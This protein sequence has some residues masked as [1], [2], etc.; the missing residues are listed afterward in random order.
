MPVR[1]KISVMLIEDSTLDARVIEK[2]LTDAS[3]VIIELEHFNRLDNG[4]DRLSRNRV[5]VLLLDLNLPDSLGTQTVIRARSRFPK[6]PIV[7]LTGTDERGMGLE[8]I[9]VGAQD[10]LPKKRMDSELLTRSLLY[11][12]QRRQVE[13]TN[14][15]LTAARKIQDR[16]APSAPPSIVSFDIA[17]VCH[18]ASIAGGDYFDYIQLSDGTWGILIADVSGHG[19]GPAMLMGEV[20]AS[21]R[22]LASVNMNPSEIVIAVNSILCRDAPDDKFITLFF[23]QLDP[24][25]RTIS[26]IGAGHEAYLLRGGSELEVLESSTISLAMDEHMNCQPTEPITLSAGDIIVLLTDGITE[27]HNAERDPFGIERCLDVVRANASRPASEIASTVYEATLQFV[28]NNNHYE[29]DATVVIVKV[30]S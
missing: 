25:Q 16:L 11:A 8:A 27:A 3:D 6:L 19:L 1:N 18:P 20:R 30:I 24:Q 21:I 29:D 7:V 5:D 23:L 17:G 13:D 26:H 22:A 28:D 10:Y 14:R 2:A 4:L 15:E 9:K 12:I